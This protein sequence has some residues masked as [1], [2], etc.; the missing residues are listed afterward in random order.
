[1]GFKSGKDNL[2]GLEVDSEK[3]IKLDSATGNIIF[4]DSGVDV[5]TLDMDTVATQAV[6]THKIDNNAALICFKQ[7][8]GVA[9]AFS[10]DGGGFGGFSH[11]KYVVLGRDSA[12]DLSNVNNAVI[13]SGGI[14]TLNQG[15][16]AITLPTATST[17]EAQQLLGWH[18]RFAINNAGTGSNNITIVR[19]DTS[20]DLILGRIAS[21]TGDANAAQGITV[22][23]NVVTFV[24][25]KAIA[26]D[27]V[28]I[29]CVL[30]TDS[31]TKY[32]VSGMAET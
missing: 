3:D 18:C 13:Y 25:N 31:I 21:C 19:G 6:F 8:D 5:V 27:Y 29:I 7:A 14:V 28:D 10:L 17:A 23:S 16:F 22:S 11:F 12:L 4:Q 20:N 1:M 24:D 15:N 9:N 2:T 30:A 32:F 26:G